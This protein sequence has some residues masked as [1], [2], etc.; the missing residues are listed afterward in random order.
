MRIIT[1]EQLKSFRER[2]NAIDKSQEPIR[3][4]R[5]VQL[6][7]DLEQSYNIPTFYSAA[8]SSMNP[9]VMRL[10]KDV[11]NARQFERR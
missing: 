7:N 4:K 8:F 9:E 6:M 5:L 10:Y 3:T 11:S 1:H 2:F